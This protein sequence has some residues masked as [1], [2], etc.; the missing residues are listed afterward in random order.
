M[1]ESYPQ[2]GANLGVQVAAQHYLLAGVVWTIPA[3]RAA[4]FH[5]HFQVAA[6][7]AQ[8]VDW[9]AR[10]P[11]LA[12][13]R[14]L[15]VVAP[16]LPDALRA[17]PTASPTVLEAQTA[18]ELPQLAGRQRL[19]AERPKSACRLQPHSLAPVEHQRCGR[20]APAQARA[21]VP[22]RRFLPPVSR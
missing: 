12:A 16:V 20:R 10:F 15:F 13:P 2:M 19:G 5:E 8:P 11:A 1:A 6:Q 18:G 9:R 22:A 3:A 14:E 4:D 7:A 21:P 17:D